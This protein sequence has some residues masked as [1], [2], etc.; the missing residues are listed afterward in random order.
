[1]DSC[2]LH[3][4]I[5]QTIYTRTLQ[6]VTLRLYKLIALRLFCYPRKEGNTMG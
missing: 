4:H 5:V 3:D 2:Y 6:L 1:M